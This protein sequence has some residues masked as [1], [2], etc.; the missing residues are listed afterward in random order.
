MLPS[1]SSTAF[2]HTA[3]DQ[4]APCASLVMPVQHQGRPPP[5]SPLSDSASRRSAAGSSL[6]M[7]PGAVAEPPP[8]TDAATSAV[9]IGPLLTAPRQSS[10]TKSQHLLPRARQNRPTYTNSRH[11]RCSS[12]SFSVRSKHLKS[13]AYY[14]QLFP[15]PMDAGLRHLLPGIPHMPNSITNGKLPPTTPHH[16]FLEFHFSLLESLCSLLKLI[17]RH[18]TLQTKGTSRLLKVMCLEHWDNIFIHRL[19]QRHGVRWKKDE[20]YITMQVLQHMGVGGS[21]V[22]DH[23]DTEREA[24]R[25]AVLLQ[26]MHQRYACCTPEKCDPSSNHW[27]WGTNGQAGC[28]YCTP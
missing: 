28:S 18:I 15:H 17:Q 11:F 3:P 20:L 2:D 21:I 16:V 22:E 5:S 25:C 24:L 4:V 23:Q 8:P 13:S 27:N 7:A 12:E 14:G 26:I 10:P 6:S 1:S 9:C 19:Q